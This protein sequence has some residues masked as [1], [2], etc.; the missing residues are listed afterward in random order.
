MRLLFSEKNKIRRLDLTDGQEYGKWSTVYRNRYDGRTYAHRI[1]L[2]RLRP[3]IV[4]S[5]AGCVDPTR[6][7]HPGCECNSHQ[8]LHHH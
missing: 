2:T 3:A 4:L 1:N 5:S 6:Q 8:Q 7:L